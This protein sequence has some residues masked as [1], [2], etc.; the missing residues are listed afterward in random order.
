[1]IQYISFTQKIF[2][3]NLSMNITSLQSKRGVHEAGTMG[4]HYLFIIYKPRDAA[5]N[6]YNYS[7]DGAGAAKRCYT[8]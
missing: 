8:S 5:M 1:M 2:S 3:N 6:F 7:M 4:H